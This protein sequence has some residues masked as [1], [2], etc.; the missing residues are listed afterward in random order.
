[1]L[2]NKKKCFFCKKGKKKI[3]MECKC[4]NLF[5]INHLL[6]ENH[7]CTFD[8]K[9]EGKEQIKNNNPKI[10]NEKIIKI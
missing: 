8:F 4:S 5:C 9:K 7:N 10:I 1:M 3:L 6:P 2:N